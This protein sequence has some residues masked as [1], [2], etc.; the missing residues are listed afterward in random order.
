VRVDRYISAVI[1]GGDLTLSQQAVLWKIGIDYVNHDTGETWVSL[2]RVARET[3][4]TVRQ[5]SRHVHALAAAGVF[6]LVDRLNGRS[7][8]I[9]FPVHPTLT[10]YVE[11][12]ENDTGSYPQPLPKTA[13]VGNPQPLPKTVKTP[14][15]NGQ[16]PCHKCPTNSY[17]PVYNPRPAAAEAVDNSDDPTPGWFKDRLVRHVEAE[18][19]DVIDPEPAPRKLE[20][21]R[22]M[23]EVSM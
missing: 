21:P 9:Q 13:G 4:A 15:K 1:A 22:M 12:A 11:T 16:D 5:V 18:T 14:A 3:G 2:A 7:Q 23:W 10:G 19:V 17:E 8:L 6:R 20:P